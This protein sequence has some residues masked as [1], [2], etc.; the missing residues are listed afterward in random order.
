[1]SE[2]LQGFLTALLFSVIIEIVWQL[3]KGWK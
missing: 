1:M 2:W 3:V